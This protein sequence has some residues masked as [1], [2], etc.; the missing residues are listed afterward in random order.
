MFI[1]NTLSYI[2][3]RI[4]CNLLFVFFLGFCNKKNWNRLF[5]V[6][7]IFILWELIAHSIIILIVSSRRRTQKNWTF[8]IFFCL[9]VL[10][11]EDAW[12]IIQELQSFAMRLFSNFAVPPQLVKSTWDYLIS[13]KNLWLLNEA[14]T[15]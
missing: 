3:M 5:L 7:Y 9:V 1:P 15:I 14:L 6:K 12:R 10:E 13:F 8:L 11:L 4:H 2:F